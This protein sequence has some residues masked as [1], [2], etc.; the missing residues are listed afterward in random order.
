MELLGKEIARAEAAKQ[1]RHLPAW[2]A[3]T[4]V[5]LALLAAPAAYWFHQQRVVQQELKSTIAGHAGDL[6]R[7]IEERL[8]SYEAVARGMRGLVEGSEQV[9]AQEFSAYVRSLHLAETAPGLQGL[10]FVQHLPGAQ[11]ER[12]LQR[13]SDLGVKSFV[14]R[15]PGNREAYAP[16]VFMEPANAANA[17]SIGFDLLSFAPTASALQLATLSDSLA[18]SERIRLIQDGAQAVAPA[19]YVIYFSAYQNGRRQRQSSS[20]DAKLLGWVSAPFRSQDVLHASSAGFPIDLLVQ[21]FDVDS[22][23]A[24]NE[25]ASLLDGKALTPGWVR[26]GPRLNDYAAEQTFA[27]GGR[28][29]R[30]Q[31]T[32]T[33]AFISAHL[34]RSHHALAAVGTLFCLAAA[35]IV[36]L[37]IT[38]RQRAFAQ[39]QQMTAEIRRLSSDIAGTLNAIPDPL[40]ELDESGRCLAYRRRAIGPG[41]RTSAQIVG[42]RV[43]ELLPAD[44]AREVMLALS[45]A[46]DAGLSAGRLIAVKLGQ[47]Q[48]WFE[49]S[50]ARKEAGGGPLV[51]FIAIARDIT[52]RVESA[53]V[54]V[55][56]QKVLSEAQRI[57]ALG[58]FWVDPRTRRWLG[59]TSSCALLG[60]GTEMS[61]DWADIE[62]SIEP[63]KREAVAALCIGRQPYGGSELEF[64]WT[65]PVDAQVRWMLLGTAQGHAPALDEEE[66]AEGLSQRFFTI[67][68]V[69]NRRRSEDQLRLLEKAVATLNDIV[70]ITDAE[71]VDLPGPRI[72]FVNN[73]FERRTGYSRAEVIG[74]TPRLLQGPGTDRKELDRIR[75]AL[76]QWQPVRAALRNYTKAGKEVWI[77]LE[78]QPIADETGWFTHWVSVERDITKRKATEEQIYRLAYFDPLTELPNRAQFI[79]STQ[80][81]IKASQTSGQ[82]GAAVLIDLDNF[83][84]VNDNWGHR[85]GDVLLKLVAQRLLIA[86]GDEGLVARLGGDEFIVVFRELGWQ[87]DAAAA[88]LSQACKALLVALGAPMVIGGREHVCTASMGVALF[89][90]LTT[91]VDELLSRSDSAMYLAKAD[92]RNTFRFFDQQLQAKLAEQALL[93]SQLR[94]AIDR[95]ELY[96][97]YQAQVDRDGKIVGVEA[98]CRWRHGERGE[99]SPGVFIP[100]AESTGCIFQLGHWVLKSACAT[101][102]NWQQQRGIDS[103]LHLSVNVSARQFHHPDFVAEVRTAVEEAA[104]DPRGLTLELTES[105]VAHDVETII[106]KMR[107]LKAMGLRL[108]LD[109]FGTGYSS[110]SYLKQLP[111]DEIKIDRSFVMHIERNPVEAEIVRTVAALGR[112]LG[113]LVVAEGVETPAQ[114]RKLLETGCAVFQGYL[115]SQPVSAELVLR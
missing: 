30:L 38:S 115:F 8:R 70:I 66:A 47:R 61:R 15:P 90:E 12:H 96:L 5:G 50:V 1:A 48:R 20:D 103:G 7:R 93:E 86:I 27:L 54:L 91:T 46:R 105:V 34:S 76:E 110:L 64:R 23:G 11:R 28:Q 35:L 114:H 24:A 106:E 72:V 83:K 95:K 69:T 41:E 111:L 67:Q 45:E 42:K 101:L 9:S 92:G 60:L 63:R 57:A 65:R 2:L 100:L 53:R 18:V 6:A 55:A 52:E 68:D 31:L 4:L 84:V 13:L 21:L 104:I 79:E 59:S 14:L 39:A 29:W 3:A 25:V 73:A 77:E 94:L 56:N 113:L 71:P 87:P 108:S 22:R 98:L 97:L 51:Q 37:L 75:R 112:S 109:D 82:L 40:I 26:P 80:A 74:Q 17:H 43:D 88:H 58:H 62:A 36:W 16:I 85:S 10:G 49:L 81:A 89:G 33:E 107:Q 19:G 44:M 102:A 32:P 99:I 78:I